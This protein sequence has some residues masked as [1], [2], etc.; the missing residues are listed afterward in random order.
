MRVS[1]VL[2][3]AVCL[4]AGCSVAHADFFDVINKVGKVA[5]AVNRTQAL[6]EGR[7]VAAA[8]GSVKGA[9]AKH[10]ASPSKHHRK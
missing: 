5:D 4:A 10:A 6:V 7:D 3:I 8:P 1:L 2:T 9:G